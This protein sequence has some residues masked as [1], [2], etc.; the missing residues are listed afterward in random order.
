MRCPQELYVF[1]CVSIIAKNGAELELTTFYLL[2]TLDFRACP[3]LYALENLAL[4]T[5]GKA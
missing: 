4:L 2:F 5:V 1:T 3:R